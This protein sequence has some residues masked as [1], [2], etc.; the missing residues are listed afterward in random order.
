[1][2]LLFTGGCASEDVEGSSMSDESL[3][4]CFTRVMELPPIKDTS[5]KKGRKDK[6]KSRTR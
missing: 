6:N 4:G 3:S 5:V 2:C 1:M